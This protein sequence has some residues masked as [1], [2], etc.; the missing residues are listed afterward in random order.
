MKMTF[1]AAAVVAA[2]GMVGSA[3][4]DTISGLFTGSYA[5][6]GVNTS[7]GNYNVG[8]LTHTWSGGTG[9]L[10]DYNG[11]HRTFCI[12]RQTVSGST[13]TFTLVAVEDAPIANSN[14]FGNPG[15]DYTNVQAHR[16]DAVARAAA[17]AGYLDGRGFY[18]GAND[19]SIGAA[20]QLAVWESIWEPTGGAGWNLAAGTFTATPS[21]AIQNVFD[22]LVASAATYYNI[23][24]PLLVRSLSTGNGQDQMILVPLPPAAWAGIGTL[25]CVL[26][27]SAIRRRR[28]ANA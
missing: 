25:G 3:T 14:N 18:V 13:Q 23:N 28:L 12:D 16:L 19:S 2:A 8:P 26:G 22:T 6:T 11:S 27:F 24:A 4:A 21:V 1:V 20:I 15:F 10:A 7:A 17:A 9:I 5:A